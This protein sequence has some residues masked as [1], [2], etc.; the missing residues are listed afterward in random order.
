MKVKGSVL[1]TRKNFVHDHFGEEGWQAVLEA[2]PEDDQEFWEDIIISSDWYDFDIGERLDKSIV[3]VLGKGDERVFEQ[4]G[5]KSAQKNL[6]SVHRSFFTPGNPQ[7]F[8]QKANSVYKLYYDT[9][10]REYKETG[11]TSG[12]MTT[13]QAETFSIPDCLTVIGWYKEALRMCGAKNIKVFEESCRA[14]GG[15]FCRYQFSWEI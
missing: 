1:K 3:E 15:E 7:S 2:L 9:G 13:Y 11:I 14:R 10:Y 5:A 8:M 12:V 4:I 6:T